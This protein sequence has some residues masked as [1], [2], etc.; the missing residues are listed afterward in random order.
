MSQT[1]VEKNP[2]IITVI[3]ISA[4]GRGRSQA[5]FLGTSLA[6]QKKTLISTDVDDLF[7]P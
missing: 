4:H 6:K 7:T 2:G 5:A 3:V 1:H